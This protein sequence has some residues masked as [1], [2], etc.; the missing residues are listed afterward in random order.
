MPHPFTTTHTLRESAASPFRSP[1]GPSGCPSSRS[2]PARAQPSTSSALRFHPVTI[3]S[4]VRVRMGVFRRRN[5]LARCRRCHRRAPQFQQ[6]DHLATEGRQCLQLQFRQ[7]PRNPVY[8]A[9]RSQ[10]QPIGSAQRRAGVKADP[11]LPQHQRIVG[12]PSVERGIGDDHQ[13]RF[14]GNRVTAKRDRTRRL[15]AHAPHAAFQPLPIG[16]PPKKSSRSGRCR[17]AQP[18]PS[19]HRTPSPARCRECESCAARQAALPRWLA[20]EGA[21]GKDGTRRSISQTC[22]RV[23]SHLRLVCSGSARQVFWPRQTPRRGAR[24]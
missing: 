9:E 15:L 1:A 19:D 12:K 21:S 7:L 11:R 24:R 16:I 17:S 18:T 10:H 3:P 8:H 23:A 14:L 5:H 6:R 22:A 20:W 13:P 2:S 4:S